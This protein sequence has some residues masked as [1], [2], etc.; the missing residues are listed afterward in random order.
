MYRI[1]ISGALLL[2]SLSIANPSKVYGQ[3]N[4]NQLL[5][6]VVEG[7]YGT[8][9]TSEQ[10]L[11]LIRFMG[12]FGLGHYVY[13]PKDDPLHRGRWRE[14][15]PD[16]TLSAFEN[17]LKA[18]DESQVT[19]WFAI[20]P[21]LSIRYS[22][23]EDFEKLKAKLGQVIDAG[24]RHVA[25]FLDDVP[26]RLQHP[27]DR[28]AY[29]NIAYAHGDLIQRLYAY[30]NERGVQLWVCPTVYADSFGEQSYLNALGPLMPPDVPLFWTGPDVASPDI[31]EADVARWTGRTGSKPLVW[32]N[33][34]VNDYEVWRP[35][36]GPY[37]SRDPDGVRST[38][39]FIANPG[40]S[41]YSSMVG[42]ATLAEMLSDP[43]GYEAAGAHER[44][45]RAMFG[46]EV[47]PKLAPIVEFYGAYGWEDHPLSGLYKP[48]MPIRVTELDSALT[49]LEVHLG[50]LGAYGGV[51]LKGLVQ[52]VDGYLQNSKRRLE[53]MKSDEKYTKVGDEL[54][55]DASLDQYTA[56]KVRQPLNVRSRDWRRVKRHPL[57]RDGVDDKQEFV[58]YDVQYAAT[59]D[60][61]YTRLSFRIGT[62]IYL[63]NQSM[64]G[65]NLAT[66]AVA[67]DPSTHQMHPSA[68]DLFVVSTPGN[69]FTELS[70]FTLKLGG[71][72]SRGIADINLR[73]ISS[74][75]HQF[76]VV[77]EPEDR[78]LFDGVRMESHNE[79]GEF[80]LMAAIPMAGKNAALLNWS[81]NLFTTVDSP[82][83]TTSTAT[84][85]WMASRRAYLG[86]P[87][88]WVRVQISD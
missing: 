6:G 56:Q 87:Q 75:F 62:F 21:G 14:L 53:N 43:A 76:A 31:T 45:L 48:G 15:Y 85:N 3:S 30:L 69:P 86:N 11:D 4:D 1:W 54:V 50:E 8:P 72:A 49:A 13:A 5:S 44:A 52:E 24:F 68:G 29:S 20:S 51:R 70:R 77:P 80:F 17:L 74:F 10:R 67:A 34:P 47:Y 26:E 88:T 73:Q 66:L 12:E 19:I 9:W 32:D 83:S 33:Y 41:I 61:L 58:Y 81:L 18:G 63:D 64:Y 60:T 22:S 55:Y 16:S 57:Y 78:Q 35:F 84:F 82:S 65:G 38:L 23:D 36:L 71:F 79:R 42:L 2:L 40:P 37:P 27:E 7:F 59:K 39:G 46:D 28:E 25:L